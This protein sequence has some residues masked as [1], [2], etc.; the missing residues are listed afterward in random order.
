M[1]T[2]TQGFFDYFTTTRAYLTGIL[3]V[4]LRYRSASF[5][6]FA[7]QNADEGIPGSVSDALGKVVVLQKS[8]S[9]RFSTA[10]RS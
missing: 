1:N 6:R 9:V 2:N 3:R 5:F 4:Y 8:L 10:I 7:D